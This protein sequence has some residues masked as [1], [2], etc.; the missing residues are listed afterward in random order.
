MAEQIN[1]RK[2][3]SRRDRSNI[4]V[5][6]FLDIPRRIAQERVPTASNVGSR[7]VTLASQPTPLI[8]FR[9]FSRA[10]FPDSCFRVLWTCHAGCAAEGREVRTEGTEDF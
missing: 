3:V 1:K 8:P 6:R 10:P 2:L 4:A 9:V 7:D 5:A